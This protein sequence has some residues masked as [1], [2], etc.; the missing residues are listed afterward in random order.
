MVS[1]ASK[2]L[3]EAREKAVADARRK[4]EIYARAA[5]V[6]LGGP[7]LR[8]RGDYL[9]IVTLGFGEIFRITMNNLNGN[10]GPNVTNGSRGIPAI[11]GKD[12][13]DG[14]SW[15]PEF[16]AVPAEYMETYYPMIVEEYSARPDSCGAGQFRGGCGIKKVYRFLADGSITYQD[17]RAH[18][19]P[20]GVAGG[21]P[22]SPSKK[23]LIRKGGEEIDLPS[24][25]SDVPVYE[26]DSLVFETAG[27]GG[28]G[29][30]SGAVAV[31]AGVSGKL[32][33]KGAADAAT[34]TSMAAS[35]AATG[36][37]DCSAAGGGGGV[38]GAFAAAGSSSSG[39]ITGLQPGSQRGARHGGRRAGRRR[40]GAWPAPWRSWTSRCRRRRPLGRRRRGRSRTARRLLGSGRAAGG[41]HGSMAPAL[42]A[43]S[44]GINVHG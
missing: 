13:L 20:Y 34:A 2:L 19:F 36:P 25:V 8:L 15:W 3:D 12:G 24:K 27:A 6:T 40:R 22:G 17:D 11:P 29:V 9:A 43:S 26:G 35:G 16:M 1:Q 38:V 30:L 31:D 7:T 42:G 37:V 5:G 32:P 14:H 44:P 39:G 33:V 18:T 21:K 28:V 23:T 4:A 10:S 41:G